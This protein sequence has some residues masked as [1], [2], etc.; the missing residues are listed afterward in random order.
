VIGHHAHV[1]QPI[2]RIG[3]L[4]VVYGLGNLLSNNTPR[5]GRLDVVDGLVVEV[6]VGD[7][8]LQRGARPGVLAVHAVPTWNERTSFAI[9]PAADTLAVAATPPQLAAD[10]RASMALTLAHV[11][12]LGADRLGVRAA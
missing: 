10:L 7:R 11:Y 3:D 4:W 5:A 12:A 6:T 8:G 1:V 2:T 9:F